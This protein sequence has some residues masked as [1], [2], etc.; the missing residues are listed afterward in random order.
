MCFFFSFFW[1]KCIGTIS[2]F[3]SNNNINNNFLQRYI[4]DWWW[5]L[6][7]AQLEA[8]LRA[9]T[10]RRRHLTL[11]SA[12][13]PFFLLFWR[14]FLSSFDTKLPVCLL[15][16]WVGW[17][18]VGGYL[19]DLGCSD[20][21]VLFPHKSLPPYLLNGTREQKKERATFQWLD[22]LQRGSGTQTAERQINLLPV[23]HRCHLIT[24]VIK[25]EN[26]R[27]TVST[28]RLLAFVVMVFW[29]ICPVEAF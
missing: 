3:W 25:K 15:P 1:Q 29:F 8:H 21:G 23:H 11:L 20:G 18:Q 7:A 5:R 4:S 28:R 9:K 13:P 10:C 14:L 22:F 12:P 2:H 27:R 24:F 19:N 6:L 17:S 16:A 26:E